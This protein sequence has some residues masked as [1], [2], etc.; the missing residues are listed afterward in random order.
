VVFQEKE[1]PNG[2]IAEDDTILHG[3][4]QENVGCPWVV[5]VH[6]GF[7][8]IGRDVQ[9]PAYGSLGYAV[10]D[11]NKQVPSL[12]R[13]ALGQRPQDDKIAASSR[14]EWSA[15]AMTL[16]VI[17]YTAEEQCCTR[18]APK[19]RPLRVRYTFESQLVEVAR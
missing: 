7:V 15:K 10:I 16:Q 12:T 13:L 5:A 4:Q 18:G 1:D 3:I 8:V 19:P 14:V 2:G 9:P 11:F 6:G 17:G